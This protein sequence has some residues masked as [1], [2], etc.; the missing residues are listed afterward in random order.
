M[1]ALHWDQRC[2]NVAAARLHLPRLSDRS[3][4]TSSNR[5]RPISL[6]LHPIILIAT[7]IC[8]ALT[9]TAIG[10]HRI[11]PRWMLDAM[12]VWA[13]GRMTLDFVLINGL[14]FHPGLIKASVLLSQ[15]LIYLP[16]FAIT[17]G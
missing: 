14:I 12:G 15:I 17:W 11:I 3:T 5:P 13:I 16:F 2:W 10:R 1:A 8:I 7:A 6:D 9:I 4:I